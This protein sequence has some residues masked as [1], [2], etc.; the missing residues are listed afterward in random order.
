MSGRKESGSGRGGAE[1]ESVN[2]EGGRKRGH[3]P[4]GSAD[5]RLTPARQ[6]LRAVDAQNLS[7]RPSCP[8]SII[9]MLGH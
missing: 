2:R 1:S 8:L 6:S 3:S 4:Q 5:S 7:L 9:L